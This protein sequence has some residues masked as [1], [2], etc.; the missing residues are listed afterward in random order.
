MAEQQARVTS[1]DDVGEG[2]VALALEVDEPLDALPGQFVLLRA[3]IDGSEETGY[4]TISSAS[5]DTSFEVTVGVDPEGEFSPWLAEREPG[6]TIQVEGPYGN[7]AYDD[8][9]DVV[10]IAGGPGIGPAVAIAERAT[11]HGHDATVI[12]QDDTPAH[13][14]RLEALSDRGQTVRL[15]GPD[16]ESLRSAI[17]DH[18]SDGTVYIFGFADFCTEAREIL[19]SVG[20]DPDSAH[21]E[22]FG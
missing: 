6:N 5:V 19:E 20:G 13:R 10:T 15:F 8:E 12:Y 4:Y 17:A 9:G 14:P 3:E 11:D 1:V 18:A 16:E 7:I 22:S 2:T 21:V